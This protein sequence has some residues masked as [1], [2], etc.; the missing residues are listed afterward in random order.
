M[1]RLMKN[2]PN[3]ETFRGPKVDP[4]ASISDSPNIRETTRSTRG[5]VDQM[6]PLIVLTYV[7]A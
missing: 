7:P 6:R 4:L 5:R 3:I 1:E 2:M